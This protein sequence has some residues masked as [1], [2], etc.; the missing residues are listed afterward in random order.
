MGLIPS[1]CEPRAGDYGTLGLRFNRLLEVCQA[2]VTI[3]STKVID[4][5]DLEIDLCGI[6]YSFTIALRFSLRL[7]TLVMDSVSFGQQFRDLCG[8]C[9]LLE[10][11]ISLASACIMDQP[12]SYILLDKMKDIDSFLEHLQAKLKDI[13]H[14]LKPEQHIPMDIRAILK[15]FKAIM[16]NLRAILV[17]FK[18]IMFNC[19]CNSRSILEVFALHLH[20]I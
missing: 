13:Q 9:R 14:D 6:S 15:H 20:L 12:F 4:L 18:A 5:W 8:T 16:F 7:F 2:L 19:L 11:L 1:G 17:H 10:T 3:S